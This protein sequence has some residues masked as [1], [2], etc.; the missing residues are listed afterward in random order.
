M[1]ACVCSGCGDTYASE[2][3]VLSSTPPRLIT[4]GAVVAP[5]TNGGV[6][7]LGLT[8]S[9]GAC[10]VPFLHVR[11]FALAHNEIT[12]RTSALF[13]SPAQLAGC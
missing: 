10:H 6:T 1:C 8:A 5:G 13:P 7:A 2:L 12:H 4:T 3:G 11:C 9:A